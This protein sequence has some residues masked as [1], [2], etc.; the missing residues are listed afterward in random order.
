MHTNDSY[1]YSCFFITYQYFNIPTIF[2]TLSMLFCDEF[3]IIHIL[4]YCN[5]THLNITTVFIIFMDLMF[6][7]ASWNCSNIVKQSYY[8]YCCVDK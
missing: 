5:S 1:D 8:I 3:T 7:D 4:V 6:T 2:F